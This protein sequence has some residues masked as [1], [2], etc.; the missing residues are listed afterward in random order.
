MFVMI[1]WCH[2][3]FHLPKSAADSFTASS[4]LIVWFMVRTLA[5]TNS[6]LST[7]FGPMGLK[8]DLAEVVRR[9]Q[10]MLSDAGHSRS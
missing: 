8:D 7:R 4:Q 5:E 9:R 1:R 3:L 6:Q 10:P 2:E